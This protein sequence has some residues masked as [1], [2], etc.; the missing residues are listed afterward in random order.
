MLITLQLTSPSLQ[1][2]VEGKSCGKPLFND[3]KDHSCSAIQSYLHKEPRRLQ[4]KLSI[5]KRPDWV[6]KNQLRI[7]VEN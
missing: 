4:G 1:S 2:F 6:V 3:V 5:I 7:A